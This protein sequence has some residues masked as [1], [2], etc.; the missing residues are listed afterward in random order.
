M[1]KKIV[2]FLLAAGVSSPALAS[3]IVVAAQ[4]QEQGNVALYNKYSHSFTTSGHKFDNPF[5][6]KEIKVDALITT[7]SG[8]KITMPMFYKGSEN[9]KTFWGFNFAPQEKGQ[10]R[11]QVAASHEEQNLL[12]KSFEFVSLNSQDK[13]FLSKDENQ[14]SWVFDNGERFR[15]VGMNIGWEAR[16]SIG[17]NP[18]YTYEYWMRQMKK[19]KINLVRTWVNAPWN[20]PLEWNKPVYGRYSDYNGKGL[21]PE[22]IERFDYLI[23]NAEKNDVNLILVMD[24]HGS[25]WAKDFDNWGNDFWKSNPYNVKNGGPAATP[26]EFFTHPDAISRYQDRLRYIVARWGYSTNIAAIEFWNEVDNAVYKE[27][28]NISD[29]AVTSWHKT[30]SEYLDKTDPYNHIQTTS[31]SHKEIEGLFASEGLDLIQTH[32]YG[33]SAV[34]TEKKIKELSQRYDKSYAVGE[35]ALGWE[36]VQDRIDEYA[37]HLHES[38]WISMFSKT[39]F[40]P[41]TWWWEDYDAAGKNFHLQYAAEFI[42]RL[43]AGDEL[44]ANSESVK[45]KYNLMNRALKNKDTHYIWVNNTKRADLKNVTVTLSGGQS[46]ELNGTYEV[47][48][49]N[50]WTGK[51]TELNKVTANENQITIQLAKLAS[52]KDVVLIL[53]PTIL[54][55]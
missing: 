8:K 52:K 25:L 41:M 39:P 3:E 1:I 43:T 34:A 29:Q 2:P 40:L 9:G 6:S 55:N 35:A 36:G 24:Y 15:G 11:Y 54:S 51:T 48:L 46:G 13:G 47:E 32:L 44:F 26:E 31:V 5:D 27:D 30:M 21:H 33:M 14:G 28:Q 50:T 42:D 38:M 7:P 20:I 23:D 4:Q 17:D 37:V 49:Y 18:E 16:L 10:Y 19:N 45:V 12:T 53:N 22:A